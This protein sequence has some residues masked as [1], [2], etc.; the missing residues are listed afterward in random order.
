MKTLFTLFLTL[1][2]ITV[3]YGQ[4]EKA[5][6]NTSRSNI[7]GNIIKP[8]DSL[9]Q[10]ANHNTARSNKNNIKDDS[11]TTSN[12][13]EQKSNSNSS[14]SNTKESITKPADSLKTSKTSANKSKKVRFK[15]GAELSDKVN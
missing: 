1:F 10:K 5:N 2:L 3:S 4:T 14:R 11:E 12:N 6:I 8:V 7:K 9:Q 13:L 15:A